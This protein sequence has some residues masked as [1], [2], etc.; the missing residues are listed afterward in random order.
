M[1]QNIDEDGADDADDEDDDGDDDDDDV[2]SLPLPGYA[3]ATAEKDT[4]VPYFCLAQRRAHS[5]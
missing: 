4:N 3:A 2:T 5:N 1:M